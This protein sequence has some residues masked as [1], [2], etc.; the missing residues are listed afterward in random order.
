MQRR[1]RLNRATSDKTKKQ[2]IFLITAII[3]ILVLLIQIGPIALNTIGGTLSSFQTSSEKQK[4]EEA[5]LEV[6]FVESIPQATDSGSIRI[7]GSSPY[8]DAEIELYVNE[9]ISDSVPLDEN[10]KFTFSDISLR[11][12]ENT[13]KL[14][15]KKGKISSF[16]TKGYLV[17][18]QKGE[19]KLEVSTP[20]DNQQFSKGDQT[21]SVQG[22]TDADNTVNINGFRAI[23]DSEGNFSYNLS[24]SEG[25]NQIKIEAFTPAGTS[26][27]K[28]L[29]V[30]YKP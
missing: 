27:T 17:T 5:T 19:A 21:I 14:R 8:S 6:P 16:F 22:K 11:E 12:G 9:N 25:D 3:I 4:I 28:E 18:Y 15:V 1:S 29:K 20:S 24:L 23:V 2:I 10:Q 13:I 30:I 7:E 26:S